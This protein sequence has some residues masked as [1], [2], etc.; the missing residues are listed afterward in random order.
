MTTIFISQFY[1][2]IKFY[3]NIKEYKFKLVITDKVSIREYLKSH[4]IRCILLTDYI[5]QKEHNTIFNKQLLDLDK[6]KKKK[7]DQKNYLN[8]YNTFRHLGN[9]DYAGAKINEICFNRVIKKFKVKKILFIG[10][11]KGS[12]FKR[13]FYTSFIKNNYKNKKIIIDFQDNYHVQSKKI[14]NMIK[15]LF[16]PNIKIFYLQSFYKVK[17]IITKLNFLKSKK[18]NILIF[19]PLFDLIYFPYKVNKTFVCKNFNFDNTET[20]EEIFFKE[21]KFPKLKN[22]KYLENYLHN[23]INQNNE[24]FAKKMNYVKNIIIKN[25]IKRIFIGCDPEPI[26]AN[27]LKK[28]STLKVKICGLQHGG[29]YLIQNHDEEHIDSDYNFSDK[30]LSYGLSKKVSKK[31]KKKIINIGSFKSIYYDKLISRDDKKIKDNNI[32]FI[33]N[34]IST[35]LSPIIG[36]LPNE[37]FLIQKEICNHLSLFNKN[38]FLKLL[39]NHDWFPL[40]NFISKKY[41]NFKIDY[42]TVNQCIKRYKPRIIILDYLGTTL[43][44][45]LYSNANIILFLD[46]NNMPK[47]DVLKILKKRVFLIKD[48]N[49]FKKTFSKIEKSAIKN[50]NNFLKEFFKL[51]QNISINFINK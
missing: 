14:L 7:K 46:K 49:E 43:Y 38:I 2:A 39:D 6:K 11:I 35:G 30:F 47:E 41:K 31:I 36:M 50:D 33:P 3:K 1:N 28:I 32:L 24:Y 9:R 18:D 4:K 40:I 15:K 34:E 48:I 10:E 44:E 22:I 51:R 26:L 27:I 8:F 13:N 25:N 17:L 19:E 20:S 5:K 37:R 42:T 23:L 12:I 21:K 29:G 16:N 45:S